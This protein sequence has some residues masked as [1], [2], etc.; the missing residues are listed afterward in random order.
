MHLACLL[1]KIQQG[2]RGKENAGSANKVT[3]T[4]SKKHSNNI[5]NENDLSFRPAADVFGDMKTAHKLGASQGE[6]MRRFTLSAHD[7]GHIR[8]ARLQQLRE[9]LKRDRVSSTTSTS[10]LS[11]SGKEQNKYKS[12]NVMGGSRLLRAARLAEHHES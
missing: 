4:I 10:Q 7:E 12:D 11:L 1:V 6:A 8:K 2:N 9:K 5:I 3:R